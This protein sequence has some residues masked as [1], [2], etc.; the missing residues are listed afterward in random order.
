M[1]EKHVAAEIQRIREA[2]ELA[3][4]A[5][6]VAWLSGDVPC[7]SCGSLVDAHT[8]HALLVQSRAALAKANA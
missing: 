5:E 6:R 7:W 1:E 8:R 3:N 2:E 4:H